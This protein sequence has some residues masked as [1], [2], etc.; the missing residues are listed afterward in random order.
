MVLEKEGA[1]KLREVPKLKELR[2]GAGHS[3]YSLAAASGISRSA[4]AGLET[5]ERVAQSRT[6]RQLAEALGVAVSELYGDRPKA[7]SRAPLNLDWALS[8]SEDEFEI[9]RAHV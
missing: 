5:G 4:I 7:V 2:E 8:A 6:V 1:T 3:Q 9:G